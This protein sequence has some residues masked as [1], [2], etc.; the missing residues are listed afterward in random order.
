M[1]CLDSALC[2]QTFQRCRRSSAMPPTMPTRIGE[3]SSHGVLGTIP[4]HGRTCAKPC[5]SATIIHASA[6]ASFA[7]QRR[8]PRIVP[9]RT[10]RPRIEATPSSF[11]TSTI[12]RPYRSGCTIR[13]SSGKSKQSRTANGIDRH[14]CA[15]CISGAGHRRR[16]DHL[17]AR[18]GPHPIEWRGKSSKGGTC[19]P[20]ATSSR[21]WPRNGSAL[22]SSSR[23]LYIRGFWQRRLMVVCRAAGE[24][25][26]L[27]P[28]RWCEVDTAFG[29]G[30]MNHT[31][32]RTTYC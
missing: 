1:R 13:K 21:S 5:S 7:P 15:H 9:S 32:R 11:G 24:R 2:K 31:P 8:R 10:I 27:P 25:G 6:Q 23:S 20:C 14:A 16:A 3:P 4:P 28:A 30:P 26:D 19:W 17:H 29:A 22:P 18:H 12:S